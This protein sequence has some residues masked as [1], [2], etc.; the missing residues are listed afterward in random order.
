MVLEVKEIVFYTFLILWDRAL[1]F[2]SNAN[3]AVYVQAR[4]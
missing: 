4:K 3:Q 2:R 1:G